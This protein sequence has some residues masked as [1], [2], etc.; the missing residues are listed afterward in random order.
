MRF[1]GITKLLQESREFSV[2]RERLQENGKVKVQ[3]RDSALP[4]VIDALFHTLEST[5][6]VVTPHA[7]SAYTTFK[8][9][10]E[11]LG[12]TKNVLHF[13]ELSQAESYHLDDI[14]LSAQR[15]SVL[16]E[17]YSNKQVIVVASIKSVTQATMQASVFENSLIQCDVNTEVSVSVILSKLV[18]I[19]YKPTISVEEHGQF[20][21]RGGILDVFSSN[22]KY[23]VRIEFFG[24]QVDEIRLFDPTT[25]RSIE[26]IQSI[27]ITPAKEKLNTTEPSE[28]NIGY[29]IT[30]YLPKSAVT[31]MARY[32]EIQNEAQ[33]QDYR[34][35]KSTQ[36]NHTNVTVSD[37]P[38]HITWSDISKQIDKSKFV[39]YTSPWSTD[40]SFN[41]KEKKQVIALPF[42]SP[43]L[44]QNSMKESVANLCKVAKAGE[45]VLVSSPYV[46]RVE[47][48]LTD[49]GCKS[50]TLL[51]VLDVD[52]NTANEV[53]LNESELREG[54]ILE[55]Q[56]KR[57]TLLTNAELIGTSRK[58]TVIQRFKRRTPAIDTLKPGDLV[59]H[60]EHGIARFIGMRKMSDEQRE[61][62]VLQYAGEDKL[63]VPVEQIERVELYRGSLNK[64]PSL[65]RLGTK[66]WARTKRTVKLATEEMAS[67][68]L[69]IYAARQITKRE[70]YTADTSWQQQM[71]SNFPYQETPDQLQAIKNVKESME[72]SVPMDML[73]CGD[74]GYG[75]TEIALR[76]AFKAVQ[77]YRQVAFIAPTT[78]LA[79]QHYETF[80]ERLAPFPVVITMLS[81]LCDFREQVKI[82]KEVKSGSVDILIGT[83]RVI[84]KDVVFLNL[85]LLIIDEEHK[86]GVA[87]KEYF[88]RRR[89]NLDVISLSATPIP[90]TLYMALS[91]AKDM[92][93]ID[94]PPEHRLPVKTY[95]VEESQ[96]VIREAILREKER[97]GQVFVLHNRVKGI[98]AFAEKI[99]HSV[100]EVSVTI[101]HGQM[102][103]KELDSVMDAFINKIYDVLVCTTIIESG[104]DIP[105]V[106]TIII[107]EPYRLGLAQ[108][109]QLRGRVG[110]SSVRGF[111]YLLISRGIRLNIK[112]EQRLKSIMDIT[113][114]GAGLEIARKDLEIRGIGNILGSQ[115]SGHIAA[116]GFNLYSRLL[117]EAVQSIKQ[118]SKGQVE[119]LQTQQPTVIEIDSIQAFIPRS[120]IADIRQRLSIYRKIARAQTTAQVN[121]VTQE[122]Q[123]RFGTLPKDVSALINKAHIRVLAQNADM[124]WVKIET[125]ITVCRL[126]HPIG[127]ALEA[128]QKKFGDNAVVRNSTITSPIGVEHPSWFKLTIA[129][130][131]RF[132]EFKQDILKLTGL[133]DTMDLVYKGK[134]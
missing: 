62:L 95:V 18:K 130:L 24:D 123:D 23:P 108:M 45:V 27:T 20:S 35:S 56:H 2:V 69:S 39:V 34:N 14:Y 98:E 94:T 57:L 28:H 103:R 30:D 68:L 113:E 132:I 53:I 122:I 46:K 127:G 1:S 13:V 59:V 87:H 17:L 74:V 29:S 79:K 124:Q 32:D 116:V 134:I 41:S 58:Q 90:R 112:A 6:L 12:T 67:D 106:N 37:T 22:S 66:D 83:H 118:E 76:A 105:N 43:P 65:T 3:M 63:Y 91:G 33:T 80:T 10:T 47:E 128:L 5:T 102:N 111:A 86:F 126:N 115:Q 21:K 100:P 88:K 125:A 4:C 11:W 81:S 117:K 19:G 85:G 25:Q 133:I 89:S 96:Q 84:Q 61:F 15:L 16:W 9:L 31:L 72:E 92:S 70:P 104:L 99:Q 109:H 119:E 7:E 51:S 114:L 48:L 54:F 82:V 78:I 40:L 93:P 121:E 49:E 131:N 71:E 36:Y 52:L 8:E 77:T 107:S 75:K 101:G 64:H 26:K 60:I 44:K 120:Y 73:I 50:R 55:S 38:Q 42:S 129:L 110:R 97:N